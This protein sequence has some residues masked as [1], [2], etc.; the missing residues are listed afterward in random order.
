MEGVAYIWFIFFDQNPLRELFQL[1]SRVK[2]LFLKP[3][4]NRI[5]LMPVPIVSQ[6]S[7]LYQQFF[8]HHITDLTILRFLR[9]KRGVLR[10]PHLLDSLFIA[11]IFN[12]QL[13]RHQVI[14]FGSLDVLLGQTL[15]NLHPLLIFVELSNNSLMESFNQLDC[16]RRDRLIFLILHYV[17][18]LVV[19]HP[20]LF[21]NLIVKIDFC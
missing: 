15:G 5:L 9:V 18:S 6:P 14:F 1:L 17:F 13:E 7:H 11:L 8:V 20:A 4:E 21:E 3:G 16:S 2:I 12:L 19:V 10:L